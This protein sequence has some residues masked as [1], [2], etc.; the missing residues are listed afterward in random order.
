MIKIE[1]T[2]VMGLEPAIR[3]IRNQTNSW[4]ES[5]SIFYDGGECHDIFGNSL[6]TV[7]PDNCE[8]TIGANDIDLML[9]MASSRAGKFRRMIT[10]LVDITAPLY[11]WEEFGTCGVNTVSSSCSIAQK[12]QAKEFT[13]YDFSYEHLFKLGANVEFDQLPQYNGEFWDSTLLLEMVIKSLNHYRQMFLE[14]NDKTYWWQIIQL[15]PSS[16]NQKR[17]VMLNYEVLSSLYQYGCSCKLDEWR[18]FCKWIKD[19]PCSEVITLKKKNA[20]EKS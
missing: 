18:E 9:R 17:T 14:T 1:K 3:G 20:F 4:N 10:V 12:I 6:Q 11:W 13:L 15:L 16:Y 5:D 8:T 2:N 19:L 7:L